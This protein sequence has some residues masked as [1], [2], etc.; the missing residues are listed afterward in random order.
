MAPR[1]RPFISANTR[2]IRAGVALT[3]AGTQWS[4]PI[5]L[6]GD[7][8]FQD[9]SSQLT[10]RLDRNLTNA[11]VQTVRG[12][13]RVT[14][15]ATAINTFTRMIVSMGIVWADSAFIDPG[16]VLAG[17]GA[18]FPNPLDESMKWIWR[19]NYV[20]TGVVGAV[21]AVSGNLERAMGGGI[22]PVHVK[23]KRKQPSLQHRL[24]F[25]YAKTLPAAGF[26]ANLAATPAQ[27]TG[28]VNV[29]MKTP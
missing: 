2:G 11:V 4:N 9:L 13:V 8:V 26:D 6:N 23:V 22:I 15:N 24:Y 10:D 3:W 7:V 27:L 25:F 14:T 20:A 16:D 5:L 18:T 17:S 29:L 12:E 19:A 28:A 1:V 21:P